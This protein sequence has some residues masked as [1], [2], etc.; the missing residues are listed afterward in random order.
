MPESAR[1]VVFVG[2]EGLDYGFLDT[3]SR[4]HP[5][6]EFQV[7]GPWKDDLRRRN[8]IFQ[9]VL[10]FSET[11]PFIQHADIGLNCIHVSSPHLRRHTLKIVQYTYCRLP[12][13]AAADVAADMPHVFPYISGDTSSIAAALDRASTFPR[14]AVPARGVRSWSE[15]LA[16]IVQ[17]LDIAAPAPSE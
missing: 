8:V 16:E 5:D 6:W 11:I 13:V 3:A 14:A 7:V 17:T 9:G 1:R 10:P 2:M 4:L 15:I 12:I